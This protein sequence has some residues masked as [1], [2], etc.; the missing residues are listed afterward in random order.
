MKK[1]LTLAYKAP[2]LEDSWR[3]FRPHIF[4]F[5]SIYLSMLALAIAAFFINVLCIVLFN[6]IGNG[7]ESASSAGEILGAI[8]TSPLNILNNLLGVLCLAVPAIYYSNEEVITFKI[9]F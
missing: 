4:T 9:L 1:Q 2:T 5:V 6:A 8:V 7:T 3:A